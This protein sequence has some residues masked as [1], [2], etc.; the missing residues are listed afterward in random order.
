MSAKPSPKFI[1][2]SVPALQPVSNK[3][4]NPAN[5]A[6]F[7]RKHQPSVP[8]PVSSYPGGPLRSEAAYSPL[9]S[10]GF[11]GRFTG[12]WRRTTA[13]QHAAKRQTA[14]N[15]KGQTPRCAPAI[16]LY[17]TRSPGGMCR[18]SLPRGP[19]AWRPGRAQGFGPSFGWSITGHSYLRDE[20]Q[21]LLA[22][23][24]FGQRSCPVA[25]AETP[26]MWPAARSS[27]SEA[28][29]TKHLNIVDVILC[30]I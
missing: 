8:P 4:A 7:P 6:S 28:G 21:A 11:T 13:G 20:L 27:F 19:T 2:H 30:Y 5:N 12:R 16:Y 23:S 15:W 25:R 14:R 18:R 26:A 24:R 17:T 22:Q 29:A 9:D 3:V 1:K 10:D